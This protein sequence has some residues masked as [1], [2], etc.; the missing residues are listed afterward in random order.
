MCSQLIISYSI[1]QRTDG[2]ADGI[3]TNHFEI[4]WDFNEIEDKFSSELKLEETDII[5]TKRK[6]KKNQKE[7]G[8]SNWTHNLWGDLESTQNTKYAIDA[9]VIKLNDC[10]LRSRRC[11]WIVKS[12]NY[13]LA[14]QF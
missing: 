5:K 10:L 8:T 4:C 2:G 7:N 6:K 3:A 9:S 12:L 13:F 14:F 1:A 11:M